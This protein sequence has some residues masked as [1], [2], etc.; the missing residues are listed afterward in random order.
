MQGFWEGFEKRAAIATGGDGGLVTQYVHKFPLRNEEEKKKY[1]ASSAGGP[2]LLGAL[3]GGAYGTAVAS[4]SHKIKTL[5]GESDLK[6]L[7][8]L[9]SGKIPG[10]GKAKLKGGALGA[11]LGGGL[12]GGFSGY[13]ALRE[14]NRGYGTTRSTH[15]MED[16]KLKAE[17]YHKP[18]FKT[19]MGLGDKD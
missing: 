13:Q 19:I 12:L 11:L 14:S 7:K 10:S 4:H 18:F 8:R 3:L 17:K 16:A 6:K 9:I 5:L 1:L 2:A 15:S